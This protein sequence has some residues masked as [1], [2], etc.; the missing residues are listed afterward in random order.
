MV[1]E[2][3]GVLY[4]LEVLNEKTA[5]MLN[6]TRSIVPYNRTFVCNESATL[7]RLLFI[8]SIAGRRRIMI[9]L[10]T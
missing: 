7:R 4:K 5:C 1:T 10:T 6:H 3:G 2:M 9:I 8:I